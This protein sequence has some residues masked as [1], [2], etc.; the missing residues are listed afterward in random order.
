[1]LERDLDD[2]LTGER[3]LAGQ[4][5][6]ADHA[7]G[8]EIGRRD[9]AEPLRLL[10]RHVERCAEHRVRVGDPD[11]GRTGTGDAEVRDRDPAVVTEH[12]VRRLDVPVR[13]A[14]QV[15]GVQRVQGLPGDVQHLLG[16]ERPA[17][18]ADLVE[19]PAL[20]E[21]HHDVRDHLAGLDPALAVVVDV[22]DPGVAERGEDH[23]LPAEPRREPDVVE[24]RRKQHLH[25]DL[26]SEHAV[27]G[28]PDLA[29]AAPA[30]PLGQRVTV[31]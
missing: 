6:V 22:D 25:R 23:G 18:R 21:L 27:V 17:L 29:H 12:Q 7:R 16:G 4:Q 26:P 13:H 8:V 19:R 9:G 1:M 24:Q 10:G 5:F 15:G 31:P 14:L 20:D 2:R 11:A 3:R 28:P 30:D